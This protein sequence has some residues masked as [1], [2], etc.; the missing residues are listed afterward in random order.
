M[1]VGLIRTNWAGTSGGPGL[2]QIA[3]NAGDGEFWTETE[4]QVAVNAMRAFWNSIAVYLP[5]AVSLTVSPVVDLYNEVN[6]D[7][8]ASEQAP[9]APTSVVGTSSSTFSMASGMKVQLNTNTIRFGRRVRGSIFIVPGAQGIYA[10]NGSVGSAIR[11][12]VNTAGT[13]FLNSIETGS[14]QVVVWSRPRTVP[15]ARIG[16][17]SNVLSV[18]TSEKVAV[19]RGRRD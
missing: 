7:L 18:E 11:T 13:T 3:I 9:T 5:S 6:G 8:I 14:M 1:T 17:L 12:A 15:T 4:A 2:T 19:L 16:A 10:T